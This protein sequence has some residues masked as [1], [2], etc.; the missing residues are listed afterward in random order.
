MATYEELRQ[1]HVADAAAMLP[2]LLERL[3]WSAELLATHRQAELRRLVRVAKDLSPWHRK[4][5][6][7]VD[8]DEVDEPML[9]E[10][11]VMTKNDLMTNFDEIVD[12]R[13]VASRRRRGPP[14]LPDR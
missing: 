2:G 5:L 7:N 8:P 3:D 12:R 11:P 1:R 4:R 10:L 13:P 14:R 6:S 9:A